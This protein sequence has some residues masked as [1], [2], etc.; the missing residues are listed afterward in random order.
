MKANLILNLV[1]LVLH[2]KKNQLIMF[3]TGM[4]TSM[5]TLFVNVAIEYTNEKVII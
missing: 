2:V 4:G 3:V 1:Y 5:Y